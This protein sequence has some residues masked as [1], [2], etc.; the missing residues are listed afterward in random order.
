MRK[1]AKEENRCQGGTAGE[2]F[3]Y[4]IERCKAN[5]HIVMCFSPIGDALRNRIRNFPSLVN[6]TTIDWFSEWPADALESVAQRFLSDVDLSDEVRQ[7]CVEMVQTFHTTTQVAKEKFFR[8]QKRYYYVTPTSYLELIQSFKRLLAEKRGEIFALKEKYSNGYACLIKTEEDVGKMQIELE[9]MKPKLIEKSAEVDAQAAV[10]EK[11]TIEAEKVR[12]V[13]DAEAS[14][15]Q[16]AADKTEG[17]KNDCQTE[18]DKAMPALRAAAKALEAIDKKDITELKTI[19]VFNPDVD[20]VMSSVCIMMGIKPESKMDPATQKK[21]TSFQGAAK[22]MMS[23]MGFLDKLLGYNKEGITEELI[24]KVKPYIENERYVPEQLKSNNI[25]ASNMAQWVIAMD[26]FYH[27]NLI[28]IPK[29]AQLAV[30]EAEFNEVN[31]KLNI[32]KAELKK[33]Q[34]QVDALRKQLKQA[35]DEKQYLQDKV[36]DVT[37]RLEKATKLI[38]GLGAQKELWLSNSEKLSDTYI[39]LTGDVLI[40]SGLIAYLGAFNSVLRDELTE[41]W[42]KRCQQK[43]IPNSGD[44]SLEKTLG[45]PVQIRDWCIDGLPSDSFSIEN[46]IITFKTSR[47][48]LYIDP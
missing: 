46:A 38:G 39:N 16:K 12:E 43:E 41:M 18:L 9:D 22:L 17:I 5:L 30:A 36:A 37:A 35:Q 4:F 23:D 47:W 3:S 24:K 7:S 2:L 28:V 34:D 20:M 13:V 48:P 33:V 11:E 8:E 44:F 26:K 21:V 40:S 14:V 1:P 15:A 6:C 29:K 32:K 25:V 10:V 27:V 45:D 19:K 31:A 42:V